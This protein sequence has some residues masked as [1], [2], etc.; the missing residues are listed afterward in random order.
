MPLRI[1]LRIHHTNGVQGS[2]L[3]FPLPGAGDK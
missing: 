3:H 1:S 2:N